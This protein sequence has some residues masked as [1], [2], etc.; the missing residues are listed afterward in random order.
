MR[1]PMLLTLK[2]TEDGSKIGY[3]RA[4]RRELPAPPARLTHRLMR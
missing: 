3:D 2:K 4:R 1:R